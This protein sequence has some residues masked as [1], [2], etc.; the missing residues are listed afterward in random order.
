MGEL[1]LRMS[2]NKA[3]FL[4]RA[5]ALGFANTR[6][7]RDASEKDGGKPLGLNTIYK[8]LDNGNFQRNSLERLAE[9]T[10]ISLDTFVTFVPG[11]E[12]SRRI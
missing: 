2:V 11:P 1:C 12:A 5:E 8:I 9:V 10:G 6:A 7:I 3:E 4:M